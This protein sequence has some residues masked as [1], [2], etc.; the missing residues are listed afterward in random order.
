MTS[1]LSNSSRCWVST[2]LAAS[3]EASS[4]FHRCRCSKSRSEPNSSQSPLAKPKS[5]ERE[6]A[7]FLY[8]RSVAGGSMSRIIGRRTGSM[9]A[10]SCLEESGQ[11][12]CG[13]H[14]TLASLMAASWGPP[15]PSIVWRPSRSPR[16]GMA[17]SGPWNGRTRAETNWSSQGQRRGR[18]RMNWRALRGILPAREKRRRRR[19]LVVATVSPTGMRWV[20]RR[21]PNPRVPG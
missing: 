13:Q 9:A 11:W 17:S 20:R 5:T 6:S 7:G 18:C 1:A 21:R 12:N 10:R 16:V 2:A 14:R 19:V 15:Q 4:C 8:E 3:A